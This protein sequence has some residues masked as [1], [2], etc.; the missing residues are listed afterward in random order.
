MHVLPRGKGKAQNLH[1]AV[2]KGSFS[3]VEELLKNGRADP[4]CALPTGATPLICAVRARRIEMLSVLVAAGANTDLRNTV[5]DSSPLSEACVLGFVEVVRRLLLLGADSDLSDRE[6]C[7]PLHWA[8]AG[9]HCEIIKLLVGAGADVDA[10]DS[11]GQSPLHWAT[12][13][14]SALTTLALL[15]AEVS[16]VDVYGRTAL[17][18]AVLSNDT[19]SIPVLVDIG[20]D[21][22]ARDL[23]GRTALRRAVN[24]QIH[25]CVLSTLLA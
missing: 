4:N 9:G 11:N 13:H 12:P 6:L 20:V 19:T 15:G 17:H 21:V 23:K 7:S 1:D 10:G 16:V 3:R 5:A 25:D 22:D 2:R 18:S 8:A 24:Y 14:P